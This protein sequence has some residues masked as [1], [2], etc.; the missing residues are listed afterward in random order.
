MIKLLLLNI[1]FLS[2]L[3]LL[4]QRD[5]LVELSFNKKLTS[6]T[7]KQRANRYRSNSVEKKMLSLPFIDD[8]S[9]Q[10]YY[11]DA[12]KWLDNNVYINSTFCVNPI[13]YGVATFDG[14]DSN[15]YPYNFVNPTA[16]GVADY[17]TS[18]PIDLTIVSDSVFLSFYYQAKGNGNQP[19]VNDSLRL[20]FFRKSD[21]TWVRQWAT[22]GI[23]LANFKLVMIPVDTAYHN[24]AFQFRFKN[25]ATLSGNVDHWNLDYVYLNENRN[26]ADT[27]LN[28]VALTGN[29]YNMLNEFT[30]MPWSHYM[31]DTIGNMANSMDVEYKNNHSANYAVFYKYKVIENNGAGLVI[32]TYPT[33]TSSK[34]VPA[35]SSLLEPQAVYNLPLNNFYFPTDDTAKTKVFQIKNYFDLNSVVDFNQHNDTVITYQVFGNYYSY[36]DG[37]AEVGYGIQG[38]GAKLANQFNIKKSDTLTS[39][40]IYFNPIKDN[41]SGKSFKLTIWSSLAPENIVYQ[42]TDYF[43]P[44]YSFTNEYLYYNLAYPIYLTAGTYYFGYQN[45]TEDFLNTGYDLNHNNQNRVFFNADGVWQNSNYAGTLMIQPVFKYD[46]PVV[47]VDEFADD[48][49]IKVFPNPC[50]GIL[51]F[52][53]SKQ[54]EICV[55]NL[56]GK[57]LID[58]P[59]N[60][61]STLDLTSLSN[62]IYFIKIFNE[63]KIQ[64]EKVIISK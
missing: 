17:L 32:E 35:Y 40:K 39:I 33:T 20:E 30:S 61:Y 49:N 45:I 23:A 9:Q 3:I 57:K 12:S 7:E 63:G 38:I 56:L 14:L 37:S 31:I 60:N 1:F 46:E 19:E 42:Q 44:I 58:F 5:T 51:H 54:V 64:T 53:E 22:S 62:G 41:Q 13:S 47:G 43:N 59:K 36:D 4:A 34:N 6:L 10:H 52:N 24:D 27:A 28:D 26:Y 21:S 25:F 15:G 11:P 50:N 8:F 55:Y 18:K 48:L 29:Y 16:Y 2:S